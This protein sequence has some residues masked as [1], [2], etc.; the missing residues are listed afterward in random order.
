MQISSALQFRS[1]KF[2]TLQG[3]DERIAREVL[4]DLKEV[5]AGR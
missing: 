3:D 4:H 5:L 1:R 2:A